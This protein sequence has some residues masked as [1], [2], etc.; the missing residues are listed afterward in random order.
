M[1]MP[2][3]RRAAPRPRRVRRAR[4]RVHCFTR[5]TR[6]ALLSRFTVKPCKAVPR[7]RCSYVNNQLSAQ[8]PRW[9]WR[10]ASFT[11]HDN[12]IPSTNRISSALMA[13]RDVETSRARGTPRR[14]HRAGRSALP[15]R[16]AIASWRPRTAHTGG[17]SGA[18]WRRRSHLVVGPRQ[19]V[20]LWWRAVAQG[21]QLEVEEEGCTR[22][23]ERWRSLVAVG[24]VGLAAHV[25]CLSY[26]HRLQGHIPGQDSFARLGGNPHLERLGGAVIME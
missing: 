15:D 9:R 20:R 13:R 5:D 26:A 21:D 22:R 6:E 7:V 8:R 14:P 16:P 12:D 19:S 2:R 18:R 11:R 25:A 17:R 10:S 23:D 1:A 24:E 3:P 4:R